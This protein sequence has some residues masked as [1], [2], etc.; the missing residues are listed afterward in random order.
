MRARLKAL[1]AALLEAVPALPEERLAQEAA[2]LVAKA[3]VREELD[4][5]PPM[6]RRR[7]S[8]WPRAARSAGG[9]ISCA[10]NSTARPTR[11]A[12]NR[13]ISS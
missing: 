12:R 2:L 13:P 5:L 11:C 1:I 8:C 3:D 7:A 10:R 9:S 6:S 4:R